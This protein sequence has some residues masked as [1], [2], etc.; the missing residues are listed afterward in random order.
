MSHDEQKA[1]FLNLLKTVRA[2]DIARATGYKDST[3][4]QVK[5]GVYDGDDSTFLARVALVYG[6][7]NCP[8][9]GIEVGYEQCRIESEQPWSAGRIKQWATCQKCPRNNT[10]PEGH[11]GGK[12]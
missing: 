4:S 11:K 9:L 12:P 6:R 8:A 10:H 1:F 3:V 7:W 2:A 5:N